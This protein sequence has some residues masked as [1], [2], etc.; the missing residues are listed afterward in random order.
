MIMTIP[1]AIVATM[2]C[3]IDRDVEVRSSKSRPE[4]GIIKLE[5]TVKNQKDETVATWETVL[6][7]PTRTK[8]Q[9]P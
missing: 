8:E 5:N 2:E 6:M 3:S 4:T 7:V 1:A 9:K